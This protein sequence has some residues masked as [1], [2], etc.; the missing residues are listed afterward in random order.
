MFNLHLIFPDNINNKDIQIHSCW[1]GVENLIKGRSKPR[2]RI[3]AP[4]YIGAIKLR[5]PDLTLRQN[6]KHF[7]NYLIDVSKACESKHPIKARWIIDTMSVMRATKVK[8]T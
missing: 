7:L 6:P 5:F 3:S 8:D 2:A 1:K 4:C